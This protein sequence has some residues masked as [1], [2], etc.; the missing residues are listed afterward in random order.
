MVTKWEEAESVLP[1][2]NSWRQAGDTPGRKNHKE[3]TKLQHL[4]TPST[5]IASPIHVK[6]KNKESSRAAR[7]QFLTC[8]ETTR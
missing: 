1:K 8:L 5:R 7:C 4:H 6:W 2:V 3:E